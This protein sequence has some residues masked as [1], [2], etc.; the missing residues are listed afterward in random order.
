VRLLLDEMLS[1]DYRPG[2]K[3]AG[4]DVQ[5]VRMHS[6]N[7]RRSR[8]GASSPARGRLPGDYRARKSA[9][10]QRSGC[11]PSWHAPRIVRGI[12]LLIFSSASGLRC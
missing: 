5:A 4:H 1:S 12:D 11:S 6:G 8:Q 10:T 2:A 3:R 7:L 9:L